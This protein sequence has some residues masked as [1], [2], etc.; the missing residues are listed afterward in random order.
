MSGSADDPA[1]GLRDP[2]RRDAG[3]PERLAD[4]AAA[5]SSSGPVLVGP[6]ALVGVPG[7]VATLLLV[8]WTVLVWSLLTRTPT[9]TEPWF[10][11]MPYVN[12]L[13]HAV[14]FGVEAVLLGLVLRADDP[15]ARRRRLLA[16]CVA[17]FLYG[18][19][20]EWRQGMIPGRDPSAHDLFTNGV[21]AFGVPWAL[22]SRRWVSGRAV[23]VLLLA[24][25]SAAW[26]RLGG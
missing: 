4:G 14:L 10:P 9:G 24:A 19:L 3:A 26:A 22:G 2:R 25:A 8:G 5:V 18:A 1:A 12:E 20:L 11:W 6:A 15:G 7:A 21:G 16:A 23:L 13:G 17:A